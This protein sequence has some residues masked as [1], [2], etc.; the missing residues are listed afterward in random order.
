MHH[1]RNRNIAIY[2]NALQRGETFTPR[3]LYYYA[4]ELQDHARYEEAIQYYKRFL[5][6]GQGWIEDNLSAC[7]KMADCHHALGN[8]QLELESS[9]RSL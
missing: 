5:E 4:N 7:G 6:T 1:D 3:D 9:I 2:E 8:E